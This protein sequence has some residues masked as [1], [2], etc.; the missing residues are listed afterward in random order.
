M[1][2]AHN[3]IGGSLPG[4][5]PRLTAPPARARGKARPRFAARMGHRVH[6]HDSAR[7]QL[8]IVGNRHFKLS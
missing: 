3:P 6:A 4:N 1:L 7:G 5:R 8:G 2:P